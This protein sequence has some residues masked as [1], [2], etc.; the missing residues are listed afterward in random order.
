MNKDVVLMAVA[1]LKQVKDILLGNLAFSPA[2]PVEIIVPDVA[3][4]EADAQAAHSQVA[5]S[6]ND[7]DTGVASANGEQHSSSEDGSNAAPVLQE[8]GRQTE[9][10]QLAPDVVPSPDPI[11]S[12]AA[13]VEPEDSAMLQEL[14]GAAYSPVAKKSE[15][16]VK[17]NLFSDFDLDPND[18]FGDL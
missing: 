13:I 9:S 5:E 4:L 10:A 2:K 7:V 18:V 8:A 14:L 11:I 12:P 15:T 1:G 6:A 16:K 17:K 3:A